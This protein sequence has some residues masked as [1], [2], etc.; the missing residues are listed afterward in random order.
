MRQLH[1]QWVLETRDLGFLPEAEVWQRCAGRTPWQLAQDPDRYP[2]ERLLAAA[3][4]V[5]RG[6]DVVSQQ[7]QL[8]QDQDAGVRYWAAVGLHA[9]GRDAAPARDAL[10]LALADR[11]PSV[12]VAAAAA[13]ASLGDVDVALPM[14][15]RHLQGEQLDVALQAARTLQLLGE[16]ARPA[17]PEMNRV[18]GSAKQQGNLAPQYMF[19]EF[20]LQAAVRRLTP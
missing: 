3:E 16:P 18:W 13:L 4:L 2:L 14:L 15:T 19:L 11:S 9:A 17:L 12:Q 6:G 20:S 8:L 7:I 1:R 10:R 5:G